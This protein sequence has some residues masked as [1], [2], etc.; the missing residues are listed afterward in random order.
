MARRGKHMAYV[1][2]VAA[3]A[4]ALAVDR[5]LLGGGTPSSAQAAALPGDPGTGEAGIAGVAAAAKASKIQLEELRPGPLAGK[6][7]DL[8]V[9]DPVAGL[10]QP[11]PSVQVPV[12]VPPPREVV[13]PIAVIPELSV[14]S[15]MISER[16]RRAIVNR[17]AVAV[18][19]SLEGATLMEINTD[20]LVFD[21]AGIRVEAPLRRE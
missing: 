11:R 3:A 12:Q 13:A 18:G 16:G 7:A 1:V 9:S 17:T 6:L 8:A 2:V 19:D 5:L 4:A 21:V 14:T 20:G 15:I 10:L